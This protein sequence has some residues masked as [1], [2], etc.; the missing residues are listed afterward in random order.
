MPILLKSRGYSGRN[1][2]S[3]KIQIVVYFIAAEEHCIWSCP[4]Y[5][6]WKLQIKSDKDGAVQKHKSRG[7]S[8]GNRTRPDSGHLSAAKKTGNARGGGNLECYLG[9]GSVLR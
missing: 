4:N 8:P 5:P 9:M 3:D 1:G 6:S 7:E 2:P